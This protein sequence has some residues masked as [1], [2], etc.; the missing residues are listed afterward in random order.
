MTLDIVAGLQGRVISDDEIGTH[1][2]AV[3]AVLERNGGQLLLRT[4]TD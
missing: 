3:E 1:R 4:D 2:A